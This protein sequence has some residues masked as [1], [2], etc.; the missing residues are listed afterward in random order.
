AV[1]AHLA[2]LGDVDL[3]ALIA[4]G[5]PVDVRGRVR[6]VKL[7]V[8]GVPV[9]LKAVPLT[10]LERRSGNLH[11]TRN[12]FRLPLYYQYGVGSLGFGAWRELAAS[13]MASDFVLSG[14]CERFPLLYHW[15]V[16]PREPTPLDDAWRERRARYVAYWNDSAAIEA[17]LEAFRAATASVALFLEYVPESL[18]TYLRRRLR[19]DRA[20]G[21]AAMVWAHDQLDEVA[22]F[23]G[24]QDVSH[25]DLHYHNVLTD[26]RAVYVTDF[27]LALG[28]GFELSP[29]ERRFFERRRLYDRCYL[30]NYLVAWLREFEDAAPRTGALAERLERYRPVSDVMAAFILALREQGKTTPYPAARLERA[31]AQVA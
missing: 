5:D 13:R 16:I 15:R 3:G 19:E 25:F 2:A 1:S 8:E 23:L 12:L 17:R 11:A 27:G 6:P 24:A 7:N 4:R 29:G 20:A 21:E 18:D 30:A 14:V 10:D 28:S 9:F 31:F 26:G 22:T